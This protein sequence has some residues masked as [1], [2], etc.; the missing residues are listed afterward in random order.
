MILRQSEGS[1]GCNGKVGGVTQEGEVHRLAGNIKATINHHNIGPNF[2]HR[3]NN[4]INQEFMPKTVSEEQVK[5]FNTQFK[6]IN[7]EL[8][9]PNHHNFSTINHVGSEACA[10]KCP[11]AQV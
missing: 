2:T 5:E 4:V 9:K 7:A 10:P 3:L 8:A 11:L 6:E 1:G